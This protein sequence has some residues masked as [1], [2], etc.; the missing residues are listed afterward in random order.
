[1]TRSGGR[2]VSR[3]LVLATMVLVLCGA[4]AW[5]ASWLPGAKQ[6]GD[7]CERSGR[8]LEVAAWRRIWLTLLPAGIALATLF[9]WAL[10]EPGVT[11]ERLLPTAA[12]VAVPIGMLWLRCAVR[13][14]L[15]LCSPRETPPIATVGLLRPKV[16]V[17]EDVRGT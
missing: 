2:A 12:F 8:R 11:D 17:T 5:L 13:A 15:A 9:G 7:R 1:S 3:D 14:C 10:Q 4:G 6:A 16:I